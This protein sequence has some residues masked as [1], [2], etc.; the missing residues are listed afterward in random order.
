MDSFTGR[1][2]KETAP[3]SSAVDPIGV[4][5]C[6]TQSV[7]PVIGDERNVIHKSQSGVAVVVFGIAG[8]DAFVSPCITAI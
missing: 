1:K 5:T 2:S 6:P 8:I 7:T 4:D 3:D